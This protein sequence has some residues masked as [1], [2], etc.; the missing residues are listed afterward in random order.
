[1]QLITPSIDY[2]QSYLN[3]I[4]ELGDEERYPFPLDFDH[5][6][7]PSMLARIDKFAKGEALAE[8]A[9]PSSTLWL[10]EAGEI[11]GVTNIRHFLS[12]QIAHCGG[13][14][15][16]SIRPS[17]RGKG[18]GSTLMKLSI[19]YLKAM[20]VKH[21][22]VHCYQSNQASAQMIIANG[23]QLHSQVV[24]GEQT[25]LRFLITDNS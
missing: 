20:D 4:S 22:Y 19:N 23:G 11:I 2:Q 6:D 25:V 8:G 13:H 9:V 12:P 3:Y 24:I 16:M 1:M 10:I 21:I 17:Y 15:G 18:L 7:F 5:Q 14:I